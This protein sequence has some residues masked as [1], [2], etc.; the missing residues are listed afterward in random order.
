MSRS[1]LPPNDVVSRCEYVSALISIMKPVFQSQ[2]S[3]LTGSP[4]G[5]GIVGKPAGGG[6]VGRR[7]DDKL[8]EVLILSRKVFL[9]L[10]APIAP[11]PI[12]LIVRAQP[13]LILLDQVW[14]H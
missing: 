3:K 8:D 10:L 5:R 12:A 13:G 1:T 4:C 2:S 14:Q 9:I 11:R 7:V 6:P